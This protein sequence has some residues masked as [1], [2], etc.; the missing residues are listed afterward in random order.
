MLKKDIAARWGR[1]EHTVKNIVRRAY[2]KLG[3]ND[4]ASAVLA[5]QAVHGFCGR[6]E[7]V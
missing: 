4:K 6:G 5:H 1:S 3:V 7:S 2:L